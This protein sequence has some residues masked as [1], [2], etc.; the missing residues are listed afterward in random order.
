LSNHSLGERCGLATL[1][2]DF[3]GVQ[4]TPI[5]GEWSATPSTLWF[6]YFYFSFA[7]RVIWMFRIKTLRV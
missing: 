6:F 1:K 7:L 2:N 4:S 5:V 3:G